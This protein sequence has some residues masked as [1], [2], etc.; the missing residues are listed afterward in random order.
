MGDSSFLG[1][2]PEA[3]IQTAL[4]LLASD[5]YL[6]KAWASWSSPDAGLPRSSSAPPSASLRKNSLARPPLQWPTKTPPDPQHQLRALAHPRPR[7]PQE[8][9]PGPRHSPDPQK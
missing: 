1:L 4:E 7:R 6:Q 8:N 5:R 2:D 3:F 9:H